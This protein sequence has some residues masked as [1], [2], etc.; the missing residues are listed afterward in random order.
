MAPTPTHSHS[1]KGKVSS[2]TVGCHSVI[3]HVIWILLYYAHANTSL[4]WILCAWSFILD[5]SI[6]RRGNSPMGIYVCV[7]MYTNVCMYVVY[8]CVCICMQGRIC[9]GA[10]GAIAPGPP[11]RGGPLYIKI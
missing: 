8:V 4:L 5:L 10:K 9:R 2:R 11:A 1:G 7:C 6:G 3:C